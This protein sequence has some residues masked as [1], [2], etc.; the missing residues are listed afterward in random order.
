MPKAVVM[1]RDREPYPHPQFAE[2][3]RRLGYNVVTHF[4]GSV[5][6]DD[7][8]LIWNRMGM[9]GAVAQA[10]EGVGAKVIVAENGWIG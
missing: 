7:V 4:S 2:G 9:G 1:I 10:F 5:A 8:L 3:L 6:P